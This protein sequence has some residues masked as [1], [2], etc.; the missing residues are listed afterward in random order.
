MYFPRSFVLFCFNLARDP[1]V[2]INCEITSNF[3][4]GEENINS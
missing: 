3:P 2:Q 1:E 4:F